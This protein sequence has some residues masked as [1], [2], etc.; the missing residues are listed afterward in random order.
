MASALPWA[1]PLEDQHG[2][3]S[4][5]P[6]VSR[7]RSSHDCSAGTFANFGFKRDTGI[8]G[9]L[10]S[11]WFGSSL[12]NKLRIRANFRTATLGSGEFHDHGTHR[13]AVAGLDLDRL[14]AGVALGAQHVFHLHRLDHG[15]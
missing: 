7:T 3:R 10:V 15:E 13:E 12:G 11:L 2:L 5:V 9:L 6:A 1:P 8:I 4:E 14:R